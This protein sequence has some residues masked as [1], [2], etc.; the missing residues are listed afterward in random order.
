[1]FTR[2]GDSRIARNNPQNKN[3]RFM[4]RPYNQISAENLFSLPIRDI[5]ELHRRGAFYML[6]TRADME[7]APTVIQEPADDKTE[8]KFAEEKTDEKEIILFAS[9]Y[10]GA[11]AYVIL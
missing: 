9:F 11:D 5:M 7:S 3:G 8:N 1:M 6:P 10:C 4:N 2:R